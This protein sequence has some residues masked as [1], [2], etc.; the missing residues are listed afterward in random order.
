MGND[1]QSQKEQCFNLLDMIPVRVV[2][3]KPDSQGLIVL[4]KPKFKWPW[5]RKHL[6][7]RMKRPH[8]R[9]QLDQKGSF[10]WKHC[11]G[12]NTVGDLAEMHRETFGKDVEPL[13]ER[14]SLFLHSLEKN[15]F[16]TYENKNKK[17]PG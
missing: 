17:E 8:Y 4:L 16:I 12:Q 2:N 14:L 9:V 11:D 13:L 6:L 10:I 5:L 7:P 15:E 3:W 1:P